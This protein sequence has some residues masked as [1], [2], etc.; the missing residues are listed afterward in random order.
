MKW[1]IVGGVLVGCALLLAAVGCGAAC[2]CCRTTTDALAAAPERVEIDGR[3]Y[4]LAANLWRDFMPMAPPDGES[5]IAALKVSPADAMPPS[6][7]L[8]IDHVW[9]LNGEKQWSVAVVRPSGAGQLPAS[10]LE[11]SVRNGPKWGPGITVDV[12]VRL[13]QGKRTW[14][15]RQAGVTIKRTD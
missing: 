5:L 4:T 3:E 1:T 10:Q 2:K 8:A 6:A 11:Q 13:R 15:V 12:V 14:L 7:D 9:V